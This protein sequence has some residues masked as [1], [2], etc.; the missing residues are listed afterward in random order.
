MGFKVYGTSRKAPDPSEAAARETAGN[1]TG[2]APGRR[3]AGRAVNGCESNAVTMIRM[4]VCSE[5]SVK[6]A[7]DQHYRTGRRIASSSTIG[8]GKAGSVEDTLHR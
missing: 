5:E 1:G 2:T 8:D 4:D 3:C 7:V 6:A